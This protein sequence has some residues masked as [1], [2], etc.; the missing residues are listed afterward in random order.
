MNTSTK[1]LPEGYVQTDEINLRKNRRLAISL[2]ILAFFVIYFS[3]SL[4]SGFAFEA[5][6][7]LIGISIDITLETFA[8]VIGLTFMLIIIHELVHGL[9]FWAFTRS[10]P[11]FALHIYYAYAG[12]P[13]WYIPTRQMAIN[14]IAPLIIIN[15]VG[16]LLMPLVPAIWALAI[17]YMLALNTGG[18]MGDLLI[19]IR[20]FK[21][22]PTSFMNDTGDVA[23]FYEHSST[24][25]Q[26]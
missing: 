13:D 5:N 15:T 20:I 8:A 12:A 23:T 25:S 24:I 19:I 6:P 14:A 9:F 16:I 10:R 7:S 21:L 3:F 1:T 26:P 18:S 2:N 11:V 22:S 4:L 17:V